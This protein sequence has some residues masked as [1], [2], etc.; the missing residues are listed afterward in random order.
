MNKHLEK[1]ALISALVS[2]VIAAILTITAAQAFITAFI[3][4]VFI[5]VSA[6]YMLLRSIRRQ[7]GGSNG[8]ITLKY[9]LGASMRLVFCTATFLALVLFLKTDGLG[10]FTGI[11]AVIITSVVG[12]LSWFTRR[13][14]EGSSIK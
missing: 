11:T 10:L 8:S 7:I 2:L 4:G 13:N 9:F 3:W 14:A 12:Y 1:I 6:V 5:M